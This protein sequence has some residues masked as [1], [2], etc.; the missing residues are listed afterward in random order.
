MNIYFKKID[1][2]NIIYIKRD[3]NINNEI[4]KD[5]EID[6]NENEIDSLYV[7]NKDIVLYSKRLLQIIKCLI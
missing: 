5:I 7:I 4:N 6:I 3:D 1:N 2:K